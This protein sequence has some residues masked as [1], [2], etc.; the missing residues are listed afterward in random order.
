MEDFILDLGKIDSD[1]LQEVVFGNIEY[2][3]EDVLRGPSIGEDCAF[4]NCENSVISIS[5][6][7]ITAAVNKI[8]RLAITISSNDVAASGIKPIGVMVVL[9]LP[10]GSTVSDLKLISRDLS[11]TA[12]ELEINIMGGHTEVT[13][14]VNQPVVIT[15]VF[16]IG[17]KSD[18]MDIKCGSGDSI[19]VTKNIAMEGTGIIA[20]DY[21]DFLKDKIQSKELDE[22]K[23]LLDSISVLD[24]G[25]ISFENGAKRMHD[26]TEGGILGAIWEMCD[27][28][29]LGVQVFSDKIPI[30]DIT[31]RICNEVRVNPLRLISSGSMLIIVSNE[32]RD[33]LIRALEDRGIKAI[34]I[35]DL[36]EKSYGLK[37]DDSIIDPPYKD[38]LYNVKDNI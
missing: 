14:A 5:T 31:E 29:N 7:P 35:G 17:R 10:K 24:D 4:L 15:T 1:I 2:R 11:D 32:K 33:L 21:S 9:L 25:L 30:L 36:K 37:I 16:G 26:I 28:E 18:Y 12:K 19:V 22:A 8:G 3:S 23:L 34:Y 27:V 38:E 20:E 6:D 13:E